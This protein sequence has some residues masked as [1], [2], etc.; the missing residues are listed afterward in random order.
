MDSSH[1]DSAAPAQAPGSDGGEVAEGLVA[2]MPDM[3]LSGAGGEDGYSCF[4]FGPMLEERQSLWLSDWF[5]SR[6]V[7]VKSRAEPEARSRLFWVYLAPA[8]SEEQA[9]RTVA[10]LQSRGVGDYRLI[11]KGS[12]QNAVSLGLF[13]SQAA[14][15]ERLQELEKKGFQPV[16]VPYTDARRLFWVDVRVASGSETLREMFVQLPARYNSVPVQ[17]AEI[18]SAAPDP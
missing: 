11:D 3:S 1:P 8:A 9:S 10:A 7:E 18:A 6:Q 4:S 14:V 5:R 16:V 13:S 12:L 17:C 2:N 15:N